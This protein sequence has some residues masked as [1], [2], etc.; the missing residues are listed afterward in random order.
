VTPSA[1][2]EAL[3]NVVMHRNF[4]RPGGHVAVTVFDD[5][6][7]IWS[8]GSLPAGITTDIL[9]GPHPSV[10]RDPLIAQMTIPYKPRSSKQQ[11]ETTE[12]GQCIIDG[13]KQDQPHSM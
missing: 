10:L 4:A 9:T 1:L 7:E 3:L 11:Y 12:A 13:E 5:R 8:T 6:V 2:R